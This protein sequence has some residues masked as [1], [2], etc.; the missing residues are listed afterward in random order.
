MSLFVRLRNW[1]A[2]PQFASVDMESEERLRIHKPILAESGLTRDVF[3]EFYELCRTLDDRHFSAASPGSRSEPASASSRPSFLKSPP[4]TSN[5]RPGWTSCSTRNR[6]RSQ[7]HQSG[8]CTESTA[9]TTS[10]T[11]RASSTNSREYWCL[12]AA[13]S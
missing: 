8:R 3:Q 9:S 12:G 6:C 2:A 1:L 4:A 13:V 7:I 5:P 10:R 11:P